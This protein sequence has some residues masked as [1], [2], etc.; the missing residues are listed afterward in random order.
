MLAFRVTR[1]NAYSCTVEK[2]F[3]LMY[4]GKQAVLVSGDSTHSGVPVDN[5]DTL[6]Q[7]GI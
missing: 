3:S 5:T 4:T 7:F 2:A 6:A 1:N